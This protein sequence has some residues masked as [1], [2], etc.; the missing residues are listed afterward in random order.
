MKDSTRKELEQGRP[1]I[2]GLDCVNFVLGCLFDDTKHTLSDE[3][4]ESCTY[5]ELIGA[6]LLARDTFEREA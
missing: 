5:E 2:N 3:I 6:L 1:V 4:A